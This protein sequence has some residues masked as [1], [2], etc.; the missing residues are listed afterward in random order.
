[1]ITKVIIRSKEEYWRSYILHGLA[2]KL[3]KEQI[4]NNLLDAFRKEIFGQITMRMKVEDWSNVPKTPEAVK[5]VENIAKQAQNKWISLCIMCARFKETHGI[6]LPS[7]IETITD[8][9]M[10]AMREKNIAVNEER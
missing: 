7:D 1:M 2:D 9:D 10:Q 6:I 4:K 5:M 3:S 8:Q